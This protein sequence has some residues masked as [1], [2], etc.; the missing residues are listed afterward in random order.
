MTDTTVPLNGRITHLSGSLLEGWVH[1]TSAP[2]QQWA[3]AIYAHGQLLALSYAE[4]YHPDAP[5]TGMHGFKVMLSDA[6]LNSS[7][8]LTLTLAN[9]TQ[10]LDTLRLPA[11]PNAEHTPATSRVQN[12]PGLTLRGWLV[13]PET[14]ASSL[15]VT[16]YEGEHPIATAQPNRT[17]HLHGKQIEAGFTLGLPFSLADGQPHTITVKDSQGR[18]LNGSP[19]TVQEW[20]QGISHWLQ[21]LAPKLPS[22]TQALLHSQLDQFEQRLARA[23]R[24]R[25]YPAWQQAFSASSQPIRQPGTLGLIWLGEPTPQ[26][27]N[28]KEAALKGLKIRHYVYHEP[29]TGDASSAYQALLEEAIHACDAIAPLESGDTLAPH[30]LAHAWNALHS[31]GTQLAYSDFDMPSGEHATRQP[32]CLPAWDPERHWCQDYLTGGLCLVR[33]HLL[34]HNA[35]PAS[36]ADEFSYAAIEAL[37][38]AGYPESAVV[39]VPHIARHRANPWLTATSDAQLARL[40]ARL[41]RQDPQAT[42]SR[43]ATQP[44]LYRLHRTLEQWPSITLVIPTRDALTLLRRCIETI[45]AHTDYPGRVH[46]LVVD[47]H[48]QQPDTHA[49]FDQLRQRPAQP[50]GRGQ[51][52]FDVLEHPYPFNYAAINNAAVAHSDSELIALVNNDI[53]A[54]HP[55]W[56]SHMAALLMR[57]NTGAVGAKLLWPNGMVQHGGVVG[58]QFGGLAGHVG[59]TWSEEDAG[60]LGMNHLTQR[61]SAVTAACLLLRKSDYQRVGGLDERAFPVGFNDVDLCLK[62]RQLGLSVLWTPEARLIHAESATRGKDEAP[63]KAARAQREMD[64]LRHRWSNALMNDPAYHPSLGL[65]VAS[66]PYTSLAMPPRT[67]SA[68]TNALPR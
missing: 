12:L 7:R 14:L 33:S 49:Y 48:S 45:E 27:L 6:Q 57:P 16:A 39:H 5:G 35:Y 44:G 19:L 66:A 25:D 18:E 37:N 21:Q 1:D 2:R 40:Q 38:A 11:P 60:Y 20:P 26:A 64:N 15:S 61:F 67:R 53:E 29:A 9:H 13:A 24:L 46:L 4:H 23:A 3:I 22:D 62:L 56:L 8:E 58:G 17:Q 68:R 10:V 59:N 30:A 65:D 32:A 43:H 41:T 50:L 47:N 63:E 42:L 55:E 51:L 36:S 52:T 34:Q 31:E 54:L 28:G